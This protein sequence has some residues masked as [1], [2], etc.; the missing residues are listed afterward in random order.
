MRT[1]GGLD[2]Q[3]LQHDMENIIRGVAVKGINIRYLRELGIGLTGVEV[4]DTQEYRNVKFQKESAEPIWGSLY[5]LC[6]SGR[7]DGWFYAVLLQWCR[8]RWLHSLLI[9]HNHALILTTVI[10]SFSLLY[11]RWIHVM[12]NTQRMIATSLSPVHIVRL[13]SPPDRFLVAESL[14]PY[15][16]RITEIKWS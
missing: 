15:G 2:S 6:W 14:I 7:S 11:G 10:R 4:L 12:M 13:L 16:I 1:S 5:L 9:Q 8:V 3:P